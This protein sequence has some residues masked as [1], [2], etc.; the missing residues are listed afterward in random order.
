MNAK[1]SKAKKAGG[2]DRLPAAEDVQR[3]PKLKRKEYERAMEDL[4]VELVKLQAWV[5]HVGRENR[6]RL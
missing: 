3:K 5:R 2:E 6:R 4:Q 1:K